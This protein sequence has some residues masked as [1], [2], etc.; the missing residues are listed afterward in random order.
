MTAPKSAVVA[1][2]TVQ[3]DQNPYLAPARRASTPS[4]P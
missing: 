1:P 2:F 3:V 4:S